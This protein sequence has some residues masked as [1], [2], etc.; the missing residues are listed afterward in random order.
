MDTQVQHGRRKIM[1][2]D[3][4]NFKIVTDERQFIVQEKKTIQ[5]GRFTNPENIGKEYYESIAYFSSL[6][7][8]LKYLGKRIVLDNDD[9]QVIK[10]KLS[11][12]QGK[13]QEFT[14][15]LEV[16]I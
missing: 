5:E 7:L 12:L 9:L 16:D 4:G 8:A 10:E 11:D 1:K 15:L 14:R 6:D 3:L 2:L 13:I